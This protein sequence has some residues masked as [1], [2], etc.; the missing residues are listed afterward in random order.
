MEMEIF[1]KLCRTRYTHCN[2]GSFQDD[3]QLKCIRL[4]LQNMF[5]INWKMYLCYNS[6]CFGIIQVFTAGE[7]SHDPSLQGV[8]CTTGR[9]TDH[10]HLKSLA[11]QPGKLSLSSGSLF[12]VYIDL[13]PQHTTVVW[14]FKRNRMQKALFCF[15]LTKFVLHWHMVMPV[16]NVLIVTPSNWL[17]G[18]RVLSS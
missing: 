5:V 3:K 7:Q 2:G 18:F 12:Y 1:Q 17:F 11:G 15:T 9:K 13:F 10:L 8:E 14:K 16:G 6:I 4:K